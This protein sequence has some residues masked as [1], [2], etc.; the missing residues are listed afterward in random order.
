MVHPAKL[1]LLEVRVMPSLKVPWTLVHKLLVT[2]K[3]TKEPQ[4]QWLCDDDHWLCPPEGQVASPEGQ[5][6]SELGYGAARLVHG[7]LQF[8]SRVVLLSACR[9]WTSL[10]K[11]LPVF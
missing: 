4:L 9:L 1:R 5:V 11:L 3:Q 2:T 7:Q 6:A 10:S 8:A